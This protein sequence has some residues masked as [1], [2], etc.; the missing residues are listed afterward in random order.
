M[1]KRYNVENL[2]RY[3]IDEI[4]AADHGDTDVN[5]DPGDIED[6]AAA[7]GPD[8]TADE[9]SQ[10]PEETDDDTA[11]DDDKEGLDAT[12]AADDTATDVDDNAGDD[13]PVTDADDNLRALLREQAVELRKVNA[14]NAALQAKLVE[15]GVISE[16]DVEDI[17]TDSTPE[18]D[19]VRQQ[20]LDGFLENMRLTSNF[21]DVDE[22]CS[23]AN[24]DDFVD[25]LTK[26]VA[27][28]QG[29]SY[30]DAYVAATD[31]IW[32]QTN[33]YRFLYENI[34][35]Y[36][37]SYQ[38][39]NTA[40]PNARTS[41]TGADKTAPNIA[42]VGGGSNNKGGWTMSKIDD[43]PEDMLSTVPSDIYDRYLK[44]DLPK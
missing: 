25:A 19:P 39:A 20:Q 30:S 16:D 15:A 29:I 6:A 17:K 4:I 1:V 24:H 42:G 27:K 35:K 9:P 41:S 33:P 31:H 3:N 21:A 37:P 11:T 34:K 13:A 7:A 18:I 43:M 22:V 12:Q 38:K 10:Y 32:S 40:T 28:E 14:T 23:Q 44:E 2:V 36:H 8:K 26:G 5:S